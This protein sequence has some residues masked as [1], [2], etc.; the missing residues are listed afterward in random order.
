MKKIK[1]LLPILLISI[2]MVTGCFKRDNLEGIEIIT[3]T[4]P[5]EF[6]TNYLYGEHSIVNSIYPDGTDTFTYKLS[7]KQLN[8]YSKKKLFIYNRVTNDKDIAVEF[9][10]RNANMLIIDATYGM[11]ITYGEEELWLNPSNLLMMTQNI[12]NGLQEYMTNSYLEKEIDKKYEEIKVT[13]SELDANLK[14]TAENASRKKI[15]V[16]SDSLKYLEKYGFE[17]IS[18]DSTNEAVSDK[19]ISS[20]IDSITNGEV[21]HI[22]LLENNDNSD[23][24][25]QVID[26]TNVET[27]TFRRLD[28]IKEEDRDENNDYFTIMNSNI[29][30][31]RNELY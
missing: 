19:T 24:V 20:T 30:L 18:L 14:L 1:Y 15:V 6:A 16:N 29:E 21:K 17:V 10:K 9:L 7:E 3:T 28:N 11:E 13:L 23:A 31:L 4:Y 26:K 8:D 27:Y 22:F 12:K 2:L 25:K 5:I